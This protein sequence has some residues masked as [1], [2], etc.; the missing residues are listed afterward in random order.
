MFV[1]QGGFTTVFP[2]FARFLRADLPRVADNEKIFNA[3]VT[4]VATNGGT[5][6]A[7]PRQIF[8][9]AV[10]ARVGLNIAGGPS[11]GVFPLLQKI[12]RETK[13]FERVDAEYNP[14]G[15][16]IN[17]NTPFIRG[18]E[19]LGSYETAMLPFELVTM[20]EMTHW[21]HRRALADPGDEAGELGHAFE[22][23]AYSTEEFQL[24]NALVERA[25]ALAKQ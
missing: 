14:I 5:R 9:V 18:C 8:S 22:R 7:T 21:L 17:F 13:K 2:K 24:R 19:K 15:D 1:P 25:Y 16:T 11:A 12:D 20:H 6:S 4:T 3:F 10:K 23:T